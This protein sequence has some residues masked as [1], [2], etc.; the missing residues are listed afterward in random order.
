MFFNPA[1]I[2][3]ICIASILGWVVAPRI[4]LMSRVGALAM[5]LAALSLALG[6][7]LEFAGPFVVPF[8]Y[9]FH[10]PFD[11]LPPLSTLMRV[12]FWGLMAWA[13]LG[14]LQSAPAKRSLM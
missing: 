7:G 14:T 10:L 4:A 12:A 6:V 9:Q 8:L 11:P 5:R 1:L 2:L 3:S 13:V